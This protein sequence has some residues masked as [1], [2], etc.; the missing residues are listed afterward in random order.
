MTHGLRRPELLEYLTCQCG[1][2]KFCSEM[3]FFVITLHYSLWALASHM[4]RHLFSYSFSHSYSLSLSLSSNFLPS[5]HPSFFSSLFFSSFL[6]L[7]SH[8][9]LQFICKE[10]KY[11]RGN[12]NIKP[13]FQGR[14][15]G[16]LC[17]KGG[18]S[19]KCTL[20]NW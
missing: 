20:R 14:V 18:G 8:F 1:L 16:Y 7:F 6:L 9:K 19:L 13:A 3:D 10:T 12:P 4:A 5:F 15:N 11:G 17:N 2:L